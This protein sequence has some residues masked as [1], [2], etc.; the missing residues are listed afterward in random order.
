MLSL[1]M[2]ENAFGTE[3]PIAAAACA[4][5]LLVISYLVCKCTYNLYFH[6]LSNFPGYKVAAL[7]FYYEF[8]HDVI[9]DGTYLWRIEEMHRKHGPIV[10]INADELHVHDPDFYS[11]I[12]AGSSRRVDKHPAAVAAYTV[13]TAGLATVDHD[14]HRLRRGIL[15]PYFSKRSI[16]ALEP[17]IN[18][19]LDRLCERFEGAISDG[20]PVH[21]DSAFNALTAD[22]IS[23]YFYGKNFD[24]LGNK[25]FKFVMQDAIQG[26]L[27]F[28]NI[29]RFLP[30]LAN[31]IQSLPIP[32]IRLI[33]PGAADLLVSKM[34]IKHKVKESLKDKENIKS[35]S[36][37]V[38]ALKDPEIPPQEKTID[39][40]VDEGTTITFAGT[41][42]TAHS[43]SVAMFHLLNNK[44]LLQRLREELSTVTKGEDGHYAC[45]RL[46]SLPFLTGCV[47]EGIRLAH[48]PVIR[49][50]RVA[51]KET[52]QYKDW[53]I[54]PGT[55]VSENTY[56][57]QMDPTIFPNPKS[58]DP[59]RWIRAEKEGINLNKYI[60]SFTKGTRLCLGI[61]LAY[62]ELY[63]AIAKIASSFDMDLF[64]TTTDDLE[65]YHVRVMGYP[66]KGAGEVKAKVVRKVS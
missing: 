63:M 19:R 18:E 25:G 66:R 52:L 22:I 38:S 30:A 61:N 26:L 58:F 14:L 5:L 35:Q 55:P 56:L 57:I 29:S 36:V 10:R 40:L 65:V 31:F 4:A 2:I 32:V 62:A 50:P 1:A 48:G 37:I 23:I 24:Y 7:G 15:S 60:V 54:P 27:K 64:E 59:E 46:E 16:T 33:N 11:N 9:K 17:T 21:L 42:T 47:Q 28:Y 6:P 3:K 45:N 43:I 13:P 41:E 12:Y 39:R 51:P 34:E 44:A 53:L 20:E 49:L 8:Y